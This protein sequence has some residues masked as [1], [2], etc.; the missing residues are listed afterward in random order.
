M[1]PTRRWWFA[2]AVIA[3]LAG[4]SFGLHAGTV[5]I[6]LPGDLGLWIGLTGTGVLI[7]VLLLARVPLVAGGDAEDAGWTEF[8]RELRRARRAGRPL[9]LLRLAAEDLSAEQDDRVPDLA[10]R[11]RELLAHVRVVDRA[12]VDDGSIYVMLPE[13]ARADAER[14][15]VRIRASVANLLPERVHLATFPADGLTSGALI[16]SVSGA[17]IDTVPTPIRPTYA[18]EVDISAFAIDEDASLSEAIRT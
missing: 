6:T 10:L 11:V 2:I 3:A 8:R 1:N 12:W 13:S 16:A 5:G 15:M 18:Q 9:T 17:T 4:A 7:A 14:M